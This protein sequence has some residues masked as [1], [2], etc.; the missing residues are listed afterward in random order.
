MIALSFIMLAL[1]VVNL[2]V[3]M[4]ISHVCTDGDISELFVVVAICVGLFYLNAKF[5]NWLMVTKDFMGV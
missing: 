1:F 5:I 2:G 4:M 3:I